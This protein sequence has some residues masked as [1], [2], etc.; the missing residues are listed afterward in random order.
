MLFGQ[1]KGLCLGRVI[2]TFLENELKSLQRSSFQLFVT[3]SSNNDITNCSRY[4]AWC[5]NYRSLNQETA[6]KFFQ[7]MVFNTKHVFVE[8][9]V[10]HKLRLGKSDVHGRQWVKPPS[11]VVI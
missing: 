6:V 11:V 8:A 2:V 1:L 3:C 5:I 4:A 7:L 10:S 9:G